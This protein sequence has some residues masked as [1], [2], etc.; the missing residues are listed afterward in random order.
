MQLGLYVN[1]F[2]GPAAPPDLSAAV[3]QAVLAEQAGFSWVVLGDRHVHPDGY[4]EVV[5]SLTWLAARTTRIG[6]ATAGIILPIHQPVLLAEQLAHVDVLSGGR[7]VAGF[8]LGYRPEEFAMVGSRPRERVPRFEEN[9]QVL[10]QLWRGE[11]VNHRGRYVTAE[12][13]FLAPRPVQQPRPQ[14]WN[15]GRVRAALERTARL[16]DGWTTSFNETVPDLAAKI[17]MY[18]SCPTG[19]GSLG[20]AVIVCR[21]GF[22][23]PTAQ[24]ARAAL[25]APLHELYR[26]YLSWKRTSPDAARYS[27]PW[28]DIAARAVVGSP[29]QCVDALGRYAALG[30]DAV[31]LRIQPPG[32]AHSDALRCLEMLGEQVL[33]QV[34]DFGAAAD[35]DAPA[36]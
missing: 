20:K 6:L 8:V 4:H 32:L 24:Q 9:L 13:A 29:E 10:D 5:T 26:E 19:A 3:E 25:E 22:C 27:Q 1:L 14:I 34:S 11:T 21:E 35:E 23:A 30:A 18:R 7:L 28:E 16:C 15:G 31:A 17:D 2:D 12:N 36:R 33:P